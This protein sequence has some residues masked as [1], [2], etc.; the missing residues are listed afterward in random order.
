MPLHPVS[1][2]LVIAGT[3][4]TAPAVALASV[5]PVVAASQ[6]TPVRE[7]PLPLG[8]SDLLEQRT[9]TQ[10]A[11]GVALTTIHRG[12]RSAHQ[13]WAVEFAIPTA[14][15][16][17]EDTQP[18]RPRR[19]AR[20]LV[21][22]LV[23]AGFEAEVQPVQQT[24]AVDVPDGLLGHRVRARET[25][26]TEEAA[27]AWLDRAVEQGFAGRVWN[28][29]WD[30]GTDAPGP[31]NVRVL[32][33][34]PASYRGS[35]GLA[36]GPDLQRRETTSALAAAEG[37]VAAV[38]GGFF[39]MDPEAGAEGDPAG[40]SVQRGVLL[41]EP[42][43]ERPVL[44]LDRRLRRAAVVRPR[45]TGSLQVDGR[46]VQLDGLNR[47]PGTIRNCGG[48]GDEPTEDPRHDVTCEDD[49]EIVAFTAA[50]GATTPQG[51]GHEIVVSQKTGRVLAVRPHRGG[52]LVEGQTIVQ[53][54]GDR[55]AEISDLA[56]GDH[57]GLD[58]RLL[59]DGHDLDD[60]QTLVVNGGPELVRGGELHVTQAA[61]GMAHPDSAGFAYGWFLQRNPRT[62]AGLDAEGG[63]HL[64]TIDGRQP[65]ELGVS[66]PEAAAVARALGMIAAINL[67]GGGS[68]T[69]VVGGE[70]VNS[71][72]DEA[73][74]RPVGDAIVIR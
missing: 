23:A 13:R 30:G 38:N 7:E 60:P 59:A 74:E 16:D 71:P 22:A 47:V 21:D 17:P 62:V 66:V 43:G 14:G 58:V 19:D 26:S 56:V 69:M 73:G 8:P 68:T 9:V 44:V 57:A 6:T 49:A 37:A 42:V 18:V 28:T 45:W 27:T 12:K 48:L 72:S 4:W 36:F 5:A 52:D 32:S 41:S 51:E 24:G 20:A 3:A 1:R 25:F 11:P 34:D 33:V 2:R 63:L 55:V 65:G 46:T 61:D 64:V 35:V 40:A 31:W 15:G 50:W 70:V 29:G 10:I 53:A 67:D 39:V 54:T